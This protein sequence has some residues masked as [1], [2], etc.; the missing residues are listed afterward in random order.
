MPGTVSAALGESLPAV[1]GI[2]RP[3][4]AEPRLGHVRPGSELRLS[5]SLLRSWKNRLSLPR[6]QIF[7]VARTELRFSEQHP[8]F[9]GP[10]PSRCR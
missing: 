8:A 10:A 2:V 3:R 5:E 4:G 9:P 7:A 6:R 1:P